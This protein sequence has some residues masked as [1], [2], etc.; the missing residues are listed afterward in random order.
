MNSKEDI[1]TVESIQPLE[2]RG[3]W[4]A[5]FRLIIIQLTKAAFGIVQ[6][7]KCNVIIIFPTNKIEHNGK[8]ISRKGKKKRR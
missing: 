8:L 7:A 6:R 5:N 4:V 2:M 3:T 1:N